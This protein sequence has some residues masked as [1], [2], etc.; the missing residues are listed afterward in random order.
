MSVRII[1][2]RR[3]CT[4]HRCGL[5]LQMSH[6]AWCVCA[7]HMDVLCKMAEPIEMPFAGR[8]LTLVSPRT[9]Y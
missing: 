7:Y 8:G 3:I 1:S 2:P 4:M 9:M 5:L 6:L